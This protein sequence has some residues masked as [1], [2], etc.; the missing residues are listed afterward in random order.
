MHVTNAVAGIACDLV[1]SL[2]PAGK[3]VDIEILDQGEGF[4]ATIAR[5]V[6][7]KS[8]PLFNRADCSNLPSTSVEVIVLQL[9]VAR[10]KV[11]E[12]WRASEVA[13]L[14]Q[15]VGKAGE[16][17]SATVKKQSRGG[18]GIRIECPYNGI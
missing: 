13:V 4:Q 2:N 5:R 14:A 17:V 10:H 16:G 11:E 12:R 3:L 18:H 9:E 1:H 6:W 8:C 7:S 15:H